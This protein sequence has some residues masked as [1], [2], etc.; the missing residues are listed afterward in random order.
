[1]QIVPLSD[2]AVAGEINRTIARM[3]RF[4]T[5]L[6]NRYLQLFSDT[7]R[8]IFVT[9]VTSAALTYL[10]KGPFASLNTR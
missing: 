5:S 8:P 7:R 10:L 1:M 2:R 9:K 3:S 4:F 6:R